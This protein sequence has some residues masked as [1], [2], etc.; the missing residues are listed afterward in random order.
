MTNELENTNKS[1]NI[2]EMVEQGKVIY[3]GIQEKENLEK[4]YTGQYIAIDVASKK[5]FIGETRDDAVAKAKIDLP[6]VIF[7]IKRIGGIDSVAR[8]YP[9]QFSRRMMHA[10]LL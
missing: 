10:R 1:L 8:R 9:F 3:A 6:N 2:D 7:F 5:Y 4:L